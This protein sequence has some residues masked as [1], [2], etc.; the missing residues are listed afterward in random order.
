MVLKKTQPFTLKGRRIWIAGHRGFVGSALRRRLQS[1]GCE[2]ITVGREKLD[3][4]QQEAVETWMSEVRPDVVVLA[5]SKVGNIVDSQ[6]HPAEFIYE[7]SIIQTNVLHAAW[8]AGVARLLL[9]AS[10]AIYGTVAHQPISEDAL[11]S[12]PMASASQWYAV[13]KIAGIM[14]CQAYR[15]QYGCDF[16][17]TVPNNLYGPGDDFSQ[18]TARAI[19]ALID[20]AHAAK[21]SGKPSMEVWGTGKPFR[22]FLYVDD[23]ADAIV[24]ILKYSDEPM[25]NVGTGSEITI[26][27]LSETIMSIVGY[28]GKATFLTE[29]PDGVP[30]MLLDSSRLRDMGWHACTGLEDGL[31][32]TYEWYLEN[33][34]VKP[35]AVE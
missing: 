2:I 13:P 29:K 26:R 24:F 10:S 20:R 16:V 27:Q 25:I 7:T 4:T 14:M 30:R 18:E 35:A 19:A 23:F 3:L 21:S 6:A 28:K 31:R 22:E 33:I 32:K 34:A 1:E 8:K 5:A 17:A 12:A 9:T 11:L 15:K